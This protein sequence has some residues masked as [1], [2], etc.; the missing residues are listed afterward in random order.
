VDDFL[1]RRTI[2][3]KKL[4]LALVFGLSLAYLGCTSGR[5]MVM[6]VPTEKIKATSSCVVEDQPTVSV[7]LEVSKMFRDKLEN[8]LFVG[9]QGSTPAFAKG[10]D[11]QIQYRFIQF[12]AG[13]QFKRWLGGG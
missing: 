5:T 9:E 11:L 8:A 2:V 6:N 3:K 4:W 1:E 7:P 13:S 10:S 12:T